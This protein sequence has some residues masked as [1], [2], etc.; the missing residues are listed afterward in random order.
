MSRRPATAIVATL[1]LAALVGLAT[2]AAAQS[3]AAAQPAAPPPLVL[4]APLYARLLDVPPFVLGAPPL[5][6]PA[7]LPALYASFIALEAFDGYSTSRGLSAGAVESNPVVRWSVQHPV[8]LW[9]V[10][11][12]AAAGSI[13]VAERLWRRNRRGQAIAVM[14]L[15]NAVMG[16]VAA[17]NVSAINASR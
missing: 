17:R 11:G 14:I 16:V 7:M 4:A 15:S 5:R 12:A 1:T 3:A 8:T 10:K 9:A 6:R 13:Y 2:P